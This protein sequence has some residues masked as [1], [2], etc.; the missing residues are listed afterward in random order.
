MNASPGLADILDARRR[1]API[2]LRTPLLRAEALSRRS[3]QDVFL[4]L[5]TMQPTGAF[6]IRGAANALMRLSP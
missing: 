2:A 4:K 3:G 1:I 6:K 5:E